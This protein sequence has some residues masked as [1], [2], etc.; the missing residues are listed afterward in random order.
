MERALLRDDLFEDRR[1][2]HQIDEVRIELSS[3]SRSDDVGR[4]RDTATAAIAPIVSD[5]VEGIGEHNDSRRKRNAIAADSFGISGAVPSFMMRED[6]LLE[7]GIEWRERRKDFGAALRMSEDG[8]PLFRTEMCLLVGDVEEGL[9]NLSD[10]VK[11]R[12]VLDDFSHMLV[13]V[14]RV[15]EYEGVGG[16]AAHMSAGVGIVGVDG[17]QECL[18]IRGGESLRGGATMSLTYDE[19]AGQ[20]SGKDGK[21]R[22]H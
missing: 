1:Q 10:V 9:V 16:D 8:S 15:G 18:H 21:G 14:H 2:E 19:G 20:N 17:I 5:R 6:T 11:E 7:I 22:A 13:E 12:D 4:L 3:A